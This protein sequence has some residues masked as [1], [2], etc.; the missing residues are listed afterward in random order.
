MPK[1][2][3]IGRPPSRSA[4][5]IAGE[6]TLSGTGRAVDVNADPLPD[7]PPHPGRLDLGALLGRPSSTWRGRLH[8]AAEETISIRS[9]KTLV[10]TSGRLTAADPGLLDLAQP[11]ARHVPNGSFPIFLARSRQTVVA[12][13]LRF[14][15]TPASTWEPAL[16]EGDD[17]EALPS[18]VYGVDSG[19]GCFADFEKAMESRRGEHLVSF[20]S[21]AGDGAYETYWGLA[22]GAVVSAAT[23]F[24]GLSERHE[25]LLT[26]RGLRR[27]QEGRLRAP[28][29]DDGSI[30]LRFENFELKTVFRMVEQ[31]RGAR[32]AHRGLEFRDTERGPVGELRPAPITQYGE[33]YESSAEVGFATRP[34][35]DVLLTVRVETTSWLQHVSSQA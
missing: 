5:V 6:S 18:N 27:F 19:R 26:F 12:A 10:L 7:A 33:R 34:S 15:A 13:H 24:G 2:I 32:L 11:F 30:E 1:R 35:D 31:E 22:G 21:G 23:Y 14:A 17:D 3:V 4:E 8:D 9:F 29:L 16:F 20:P 25:V 28:L